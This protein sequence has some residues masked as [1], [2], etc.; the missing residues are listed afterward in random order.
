MAKPARKR[1]EKSP[2]RSIFPWGHSRWGEKLTR[3]SLEPKH[4]LAGWGGGGEVDLAGLVLRA[5]QKNRASR[6]GKPGL[7][8]LLPC[9]VHQG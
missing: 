2:Q 1:S 5:K 3:R 4:A 6:V 7:F 8:S 9:R